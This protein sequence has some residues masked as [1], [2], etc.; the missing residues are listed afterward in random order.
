MSVPELGCIE[1]CPFTGELL[2]CLSWPN[3][4]KLWYANSSVCARFAAD[5]AKVESKTTGVTIHEPG[6]PRLETYPALI[7]PTAVGEEPNPD[8]FARFQR[9]AHDNLARWEGVNDDFSKLLSLRVTSATK[10][11]RA[12][13]LTWCFRVG[14]VGFEPTTQGL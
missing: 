13:A 10:K 8:G 2:S 9:N 11:V 1:N 3:G 12:K 6:I 5:L 4:S 7:L 14:P